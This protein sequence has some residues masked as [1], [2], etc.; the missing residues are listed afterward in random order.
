MH[1]VGSYN[2]FGEDRVGGSA[3]DAVKFATY[4]RDS[5]SVLDYANNCYY[6]SGSARFTS[7]DPYKASAGPSDPATWNRYTYVSGDPVAFNDPTGL[8]QCLV[9]VTT[10]IDFDGEKTVTNN[11]VECDDLPS[12]SIMRLAAQAGNVP[13]PN[14]GG[15]GLNP[16]QM[17]TF[18]AAFNDAL[19]KLA[20]LTKCSRDC[21][22][23]G[24]D[25][26]QSAHFNYGIIPSDVDVVAG[27]TTFAETDRYT[28]TV[29]PGDGVV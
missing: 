13:V 16:G 26:V 24:L 1:S 10:V 3:N 25:V 11:W 20:K 27:E 28:Q 5:V 29:R 23:V 17:P 21:D 7:P 4:V 18:K 2:P 8:G 19:N 15:I 14:V 6:S 12:F 22:N 9:S